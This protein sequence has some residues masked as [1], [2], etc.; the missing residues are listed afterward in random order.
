MTWTDK[1]FQPL[2][3][4][5]CDYHSEDGVRFS[6]PFY[7]DLSQ[8]QRK[9]L[10]NA[11]RTTIAATTTSTS[12]PK[13]MSG[14]SVETRT[15]VEYS[16]EQYIGLGI[17]VLRSVI[18]SRGGIPADLILRIQAVTGEVIVTDAQ[19]KKAFDTRKK[20]VLDYVKNNP[21]PSF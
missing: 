13:S 9:Q 10:F 18:H 7:L 11:V 3:S 6:L 17:D 12:V 19:L 14:I 8:Q 15:P 5:A 2:N 20:Y 4:A 21:P 16:V 1:P